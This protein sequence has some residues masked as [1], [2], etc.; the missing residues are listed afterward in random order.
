M[1]L[2]SKYDLIE[3]IVQSTDEAL[4]LQVKNLLD[5]EEVESWSQ[6]DA[7]LKASLLRGLKQIKKEE[8]KPHSVVFKRLKKAYGVK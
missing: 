6:I 8:T 5:E 7:N 1:S 3:K 4:L 2:I